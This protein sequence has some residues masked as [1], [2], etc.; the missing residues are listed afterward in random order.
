MLFRRKRPLTSPEIIMPL[1][2]DWAREHGLTYAA[3]LGLKPQVVTQDPAVC[4]HILRANLSNYVK[5]FGY[6]VA[7]PLIGRGLLRSEGALWHAQRA[8][9]DRGF[10]HSFL[11]RAARVS[12]RA[13]GAS[14]REPP[15]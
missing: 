14:A 12:A 1:T 9:V 4:K 5:N 13:A 2:L 7:A 15:L 3:F 8:L 6:D 10:H 11:A